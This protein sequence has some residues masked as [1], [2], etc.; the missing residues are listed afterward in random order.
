MNKVQYARYAAM[1]LSAA[2]FISMTVLIKPWEGRSYK[3]YYDAG[4]VLTVC[5]GH[6]GSDI[7]INKIY[8]DY[9]CDVMTV[10]DTVIAERSVDRGL[11]VSVPQ[12]TKAAFISFE[13]NTGGFHGSTLQKKVNAGDIEGACNQ[14]SRWVYVDGRVLRGLQNRRIYGDAYRLSERDLCLAGL[15]KRSPW[16]QSLIGRFL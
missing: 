14:L 8:T 11:R 3:P 13:F 5:D 4:G 10:K 2:G 6:T 7:N 16:Y 15:G 1:G 12:E 9:E